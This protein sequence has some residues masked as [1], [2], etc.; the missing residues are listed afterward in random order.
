MI[1]SYV[2]SSTKTLNSMKLNG[3]EI[4]FLDLHKFVKN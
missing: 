2:L 1:V 3:M 4:F